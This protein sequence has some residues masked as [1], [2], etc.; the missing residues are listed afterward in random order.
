[1]IRRMIEGGYTT[2]R[3][4]ARGDEDAAGAAP[5]QYCARRALR[6]AVSNRWR[7]PSCHKQ[8]DQNRHTR[9][10]HTVNTHKPRRSSNS[11]APQSVA[12]ST[13]AHTEGETVES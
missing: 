3:T 5:G 7:R 2:Q 8:Q 10:G 4:D 13:V 11:T 9:T 1:M 6:G 12:A